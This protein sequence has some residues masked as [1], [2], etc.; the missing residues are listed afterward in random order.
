MTKIC[1][2]A[3]VLVAACSIALAQSP[4]P[5]PGEA[6]A[7]EQESGTGTA[8]GAEPRESARLSLIEGITDNT[9]TH[10]GFAFSS[11]EMYTTDAFQGT[12]SEG[13]TSTMLYPQIFTNVHGRRSQLHLDYSLGY[14]MYQHQRGINTSAH[15]ALMSWNMRLARSTF[16]Q[17]SDSFS[18]SPND[19]G[20][21]LGQPV[22]FSQ[23]SQLSEIQIQPIYSQEILVNHQR[24]VRNS[25]AAG[26][27]HDVSRKMTVSLLGSYDYL[28]YRQA[29]FANTHGFQVGLRLA[30]QF[31]KWLFLDS[32]YST[33][34]NSVNSA[35]GSSS[36]Q[37]LQVGGFRFRISPTTQLF[38][39]GT[40]EYTHDLGGRTVAG[41]EGG[42]SRSSKSN[43]IRI[44]YHRGLSTTSGPG[45]ILQGND[46]TLAFVHRLSARM[47]FQMD[48]TYMNGLGF[49][50]GASLQSFYGNGG[51]QIRLQRNLV[52][53]TNVGYISQ[54][55]RKLPFSAPNLKGYT[56]FV[57]LQYFMP[58]LRG[59]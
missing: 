15:T 20:F 11:Y 59:R 9:A 4:K 26:V 28:K 50:R 6:P 51:I 35:L 40:V 25:A 27:S 5:E 44:N 23:F 2:A 56:A 1:C 21:S 31:T 45:T 30:Y 13:V 3:S 29:G 54:Q 38:T 41:F 17:F 47:S 34:L 14:R 19:Y 58:A 55:Q 10:L 48:G 37:R 49:L 7:I 43:S 33:Y 46:V 57:G 24:L 36:I 52:A 16:F 12:T 18:S 42:L 22:Q 39:T 8:T 32:S 53:S